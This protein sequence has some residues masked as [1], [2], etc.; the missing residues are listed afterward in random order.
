VGIVDIR[1]ADRPQQL[2]ALDVG[3]EPTSVSALGDIAVA[4]VWVDKPQIGKPAPSFKPGKLLVLDVSRR[5]DPKVLG[6]VAIGYHP[7]SVK[8]TRIGK[9]LVVVVAIENQPVIVENGLVID[10]DVPGHPGD[11]S[12][13]GLV[14][15]ITLDL[16]DVTKSTVADVV[17]PEAAMKSAGLEFAADPQP[18][19][20]DVHGS[21]A[22]VTLQENNGLAFL[23][24]ADPRKP[25]LRRLAYLGTCADRSA[26]MTEDDAISFTETYPKDATGARQ[27]KDGAG[28]PIPAGSRMPDAV[29]FSPDGSIVFTADE[30]ELNFT[31]GRGVSAW[32][33]NGNL[34]WEDKGLLESVAVSFSHYPEGR[35]E[36]KGAEFEGV[37]TATFGRDDYAFFL[38][39]RGSFMAVF[40]INAAR[41]PRLLQIVPTGISPEGVVAIPSRDLVVT[42]DEGSGT[43][44]IL[45][46]SHRDPRSK[47]APQL[48]S[49]SVDQPWAA[50]SGLTAA[51]HGESL[52]AVPDNAL[53]TSIFRID[54]GRPEARV[55]EVL[56][57]KRDGK[58]ARYDG[59][60][61]VRDHS[62][63]RPGFA[64]FW[65][66]S[67]G[68]GS[69]NPNLL[70][71]IDGRGN[72][73]REIQL[74]FTIDAA[75][76]ATLKGFAQPAKGG[77]KIRSNGFEG[78][79][80]ST[81]GRY[82][83]A[84][85]QRDFAGE[86]TSPKY[87]RIARYD[88]QQLVNPAAGV[89]N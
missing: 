80:M 46:G 26:D 11:V 21:S 44:T 85:I 22:V 1:R 82:L 34:A 27:P 54:V 64:G 13:P 16:S 72:V 37:T 51:E 8:L 7:D 31:G 49:R 69:S 45:R 41:R 57:V 29:A 55:V 42:A 30:G 67:E 60:G 47:R 50:F 83:F 20:V 81:D 62:I 33:N 14:Q 40:D 32:F 36:N 58:Q 73:L 76:D 70:V 61:L 15:V 74:P 3:G 28:R 66:A 84:A 48:Y 63:L 52:Y 89:C 53:P 88:L 39:E 23:D 43:L 65:I 19:F 59:E 4:A 71:Q 35:S 17:L 5:D 6:E 38:S 87:T 10:S 24:I 2:K 75:A 9:E 25:A 78:V 18:E 77:Q 68:N 86:F 12:P 79:A 56:K